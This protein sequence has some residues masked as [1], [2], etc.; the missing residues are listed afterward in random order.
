[1]IAASI[2]RFWSKVEK[3]GTCWLW[4]GGHYNTGYGLF[5]VEGKSRGAHRVAYTLTTGTEPPAGMHL[6]HLC[7]NPSCVNPS[8]LEVVTP[9]E[10]TRRGIGPSA[11]NAVATHCRY[12]HEFSDENTYVWRNRKTGRSHRVCRACHRATMARR[13]A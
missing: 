1:M 7:R 2:N 3:T 4:L 6:D 9:R 10:N 5:H 13:R 8:H 11:K 12:G